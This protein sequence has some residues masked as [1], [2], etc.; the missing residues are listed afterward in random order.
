MKEK[1][2]C[3]TW[4]PVRSTHQHAIKAN[5]FLFSTVC[6]YD[7]EGNTVSGGIEAQT[8]QLMENM[9][10]LL[11]GE[12]LTLDDVVDITA[13]ITDH[14]DFAR[15]NE[16]YYSYFPVTTPMRA[17][18]EVN[19]LADDLAVEMKMIAALKG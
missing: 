12:G 7:P 6:G 18:V 13:F 17:C 9:K 8:K 1:V 14:N 3:K 2:F 10:D 5:G 15:M 11:A 16:V 19:W 4:G